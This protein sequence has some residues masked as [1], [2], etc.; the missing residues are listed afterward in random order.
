MTRLMMPLSFFLLLS[1][2]FFS[3]PAT[4]RYDGR[5]DNKPVAELELMNNQDLLSEM[6][7]VCLSIVMMGPLYGPQLSL[8]GI[9]YARVIERVSRKQH[10]G[11][12]PK[13][14]SDLLKGTLEGSQQKCDQ[15]F[16]AFI[17]EKK[18]ENQR[19]SLNP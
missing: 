15:A 16:T 1:T 12:S 8:D 2:V 7:G 4:A 11:K 9:R 14:M 6:M 10:G 5:Q 17:E 18:R 19:K 13:W 3:S